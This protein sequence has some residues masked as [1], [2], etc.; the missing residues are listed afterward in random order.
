MVLGRGR[1]FVLSLS[2]LA[3]GA[4]LG[5]GCQMRRPV[6]RGMPPGSSTLCVFGVRGVRAFTR[7]TDDGMDITFTVVGDGSLLRERAHE[8]LNGAYPLKPET[9]AIARR[10]HATIHDEPAG[11]TI[12]A[13]PTDPAD[14]EGVRAAILHR[15]DEVTSDDCD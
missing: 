6:A 13:T 14:L 9:A 15:L 10:V 12:H 3:T 11:L 5:T 2:V 7:D 1:A 4:L 8:S